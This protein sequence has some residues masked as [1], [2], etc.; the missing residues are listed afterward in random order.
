MVYHENREYKSGFPIHAT[1]FKN[2]NFLAHWHSE[3]EIALVCEGNLTMS[4]NCETK[5]LEK[6][7]IAICTGGD[8]HYYDKK[9]TDSTVLIIVFRPELIDKIVKL[10]SG[11][12]FSYPFIDKSTISGLGLSVNDIDEMKACINYIYREIQRQDTHYQILVASRLIELIGLFLRHLPQQPIE[13]DNYD[14]AG[15]SIRLIQKAIKFIEHN[16]LYSISLQDVSNHLGISPAYFSKIFNK[17][18]GQNFKAYLNTIRIEKVNNLL[19]SSPDPIIDIAYGCGFNSIRTFN[20]VYKSIKGYSPSDIRLSIM[21]QK[22]P[23]RINM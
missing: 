3:I 6:G 9:N 18:T 1:V 5:V 13:R 17:I 23:L 4:I 12:H 14:T 16:Y 22:D 15:G 11:L 2:I 7:D 10:P 8:I 21:K 20:R 19:K